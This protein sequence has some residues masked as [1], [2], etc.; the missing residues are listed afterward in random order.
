M[1]AVRADMR[2]LPVK[3]ILLRKRTLHSI[4]TRVVRELKRLNLYE[5]ADV[6]SMG[7]TLETLGYC[8]PG[9]RPRIEIPTLT[10]GRLVQWLFP[11]TDRYYSAAD[12]LRHEY[13]HAFDSRRHSAA[14]RRERWQRFGRSKR[15]IDP[16]PERH[17]TDYAA[18]HPE[19]DFAECFMMFVKWGGEWRHRRL[20]GRG[21]PAGVW[22]KMAFLERVS[23]RARGTGWNRS[24]AP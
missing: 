13:G 7:I 10:I 24:G 11:W 22:A 19:E 23:K 16:D 3:T 12:T 15:A 17:I 20:P 21:N 4:N 14:F 6:A 5:P 8:T 9:K 1:L 18:K 2:R